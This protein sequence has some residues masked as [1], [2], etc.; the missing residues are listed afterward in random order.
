MFKVSTINLE[1]QLDSIRSFK[2]VDRQWSP[3]LLSVLKSLNTFK[4]QAVLVAVFGGTYPF[5]ITCISSQLLGSVKRDHK[6]SL[7]FFGGGCKGGKPGEVF[8]PS[9]APLKSP[10]R[11]PAKPSKT[12]KPDR[13]V[14]K[15]VL[16]SLWL[17]KRAQKAM[18]QSVTTV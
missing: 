10:R 6:D 15:L 16:T 14:S 13:S 5:E 4:P 18:T 3:W 8:S 12:D 9:M 11:S 1:S 17:G 2:Q 7:S